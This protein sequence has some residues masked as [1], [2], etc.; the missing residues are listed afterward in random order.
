MRAH[1]IFPSATSRNTKMLPIMQVDGSSCVRTSMM[2]MAACVENGGCRSCSSL[3]ASCILPGSRSGLVLKDCATFTKV[4]PVEDSQAAT[5]SSVFRNRDL[6]GDGCVVRVLTQF[7]NRLLH[8]ARL[9][10]LRPS[11]QA[12]GVTCTCLEG[13]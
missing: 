10:L 2:V 11:R 12:L 6:A 8:F 5:T 9:A 7:H 1:Q 13:K 4:G 3:K